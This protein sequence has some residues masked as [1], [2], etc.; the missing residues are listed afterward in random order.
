MQLERSAQS[1]VQQQKGYSGQR[2]RV[3]HMNSLVKVDGIL[4]EVVDIAGS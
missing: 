2:I 3:E 4:G 1:F